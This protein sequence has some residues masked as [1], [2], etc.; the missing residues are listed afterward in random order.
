MKTF[1]CQMNIEQIRQTLKNLFEFENPIRKAEIFLH[2]STNISGITHSF[3]EILYKTNNN[4]TKIIGFLKQ[5]YCRIKNFKFVSWHL[6][7]KLRYLFPI[8][9]LKIQSFR[10]NLGRN[11]SNAY[12]IQPTVPI[13]VRKSLCVRLR[14]R[15]NRIFKYRIEIIEIDILKLNN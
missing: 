15:R 11:S 4:K 1:H 6:F 9:S 10:S 8:T 7:S 2:L 5:L 3:P 14:M 13:F 12:I